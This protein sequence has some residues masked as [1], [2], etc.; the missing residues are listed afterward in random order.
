[1]I[2]KVWAWDEVFYVRVIGDELY[3][4][5]RSA[6]FRFSGKYDWTGQFLVG[7]TGHIA[8]LPEYMGV[9]IEKYEVGK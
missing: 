5:A 7:S 6:D 2:K 4:I 1:M 9:V 3:E 8:Y